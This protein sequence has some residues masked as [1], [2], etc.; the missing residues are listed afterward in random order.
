MPGHGVQGDAS[1]YSA[2]F[3]TVGLAALEEEGIKLAAVLD[4]DGAFA[5]ASMVRQAV[6]TL[7]DKLKLI[8]REIAAVAQ[9]EI[10]REEVEGRVRPD[11]GGDGGERLEDYIGRSH[12]LDAV[13]GSVGVNYEPILYERVP[14]WWTN[15][16]GYSGH[17][18]R[19][20]HGF[21][22][23]AGWTGASRPDPGQ[24]R[25]HPLFAPQGSQRDSNVY[26]PD[27]DFQPAAKGPKGTRPG[28]HI[29]NP[30][31]ERR[32][33][34]KGAQRAEGEWHRRV[35]AARAHFVQT[36]DRAVAQA[37]RPAPR[38]TGRRG[39]RR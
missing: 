2:V 10:V 17:V 19:T 18:G 22:F 25:E 6:I 32:F 33:V 11:T 35:R 3:A 30:I 7:L 28:M 21:F 34:Q 38:P 16:E 4:A 24:F 13:E 14:W 5:Q 8:A 1:A 26:G 39:R 20:V 31:P 27:H 15:E 29:R 36:I 23:D 37:A 12:P 9:E